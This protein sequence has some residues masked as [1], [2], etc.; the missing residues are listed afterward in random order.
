MKNGPYILVNAPIDY[1]GKKYRER[2]VYEHVLNWWKETNIIPPEGYQ[3]HH[4]NGCK[5]DNRFCNLE[6]VFKSTHVKLHPKKKE[7]FILICKWCQKPFKRDSRNYKTKVKLG[8]KNFYCCRSH[9]VKDQ[10]SILHRSSVGSQRRIVN[11]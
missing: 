11:P 1:P 3:I 4:K 8:Q 7:E 5:T 2:Y 6:M 9:Q 10:R